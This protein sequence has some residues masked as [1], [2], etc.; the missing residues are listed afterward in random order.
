MLAEE[1]VKAD[2]HLGVIVDDWIEQRG[3]AG[4]D[5]ELFTELARQALF[6]AFAVFL[7]AAGELPEPAERVVIFPL[8]DEN[9]SPL[10]NDRN[11]G[12]DALH[13]GELF[14]CE[15]RKNPTEMKL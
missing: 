8:A 13:D 12:I 6:E 15:N 2:E 9:F 11:G 7:L 14:T 1:R 5:V 3:G 4:G 10:E